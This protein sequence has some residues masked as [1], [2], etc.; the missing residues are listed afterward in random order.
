[1]GPKLI[2]VI[3]FIQIASTFVLNYSAQLN[4]FYLNKSY[5]P[6]ALAKDKNI[7]T[8][9]LKFMFLTILG[10]VFLF[11]LEVT[12]KIYLVSQL[13]LVLPPF[14]FIPGSTAFSEKYEAWFNE[15]L[16]TLTNMNTA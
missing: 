10:P 9:I 12:N 13:V 6:K 7:C 11:F 8:K 14:Y 4:S 2:I 15:T 5:E 1:M 3:I 16:Y